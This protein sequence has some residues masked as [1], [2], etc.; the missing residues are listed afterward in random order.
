MSWENN[1]YYNPENSGV[2]I[3]DSIDIAG[4]YEFDIFVIWRL[5][6]GQYGWAND[7]GCSCPTP[8]EDVGLEDLVI[9][10]LKDAVNDLKAWYGNSYDQNPGNTLAVAYLA[11]KLEA[12]DARVHQG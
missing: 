10:S 4:P 3:V 9:G 6:D 12:L 11:E 2:E 5:A 7:S 8:F 1:L